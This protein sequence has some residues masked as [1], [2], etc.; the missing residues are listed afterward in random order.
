MTIHL[1]KYY[2]FVPNIKDKFI[3]N[4]TKS[5]IISIQLFLLLRKEREMEEKEILDVTE[6]IKDYIEKIMKEEC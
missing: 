2:S 6:E 3:E 1:K 5:W 4:I